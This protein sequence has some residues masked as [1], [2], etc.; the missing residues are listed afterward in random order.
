MHEAGGHH[1]RF[2]LTADHL[3]EEDGREFTVVPS[4][5][6]VAVAGGLAK[7]CAQVLGALFGE[8]QEQL[9]IDQRIRVQFPGIILLSLSELIINETLCSSKIVAEV[10]A[11]TC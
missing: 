11:W 7:V 8:A 1:L 3:A 4:V 5:A 10:R 2:P 9:A 6:H